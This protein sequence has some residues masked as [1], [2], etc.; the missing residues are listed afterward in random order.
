[1]KMDFFKAKAAHIRMGRRGE[2]AACRLLEWKGLEVLARDCKTPR[3][4]IDIVARD[5]ATLVFAEVKTKRASSRSR[6][7][8]NLSRRQ[9]ARIYRAAFSYMKDIGSP[10][11]PFRF[12]VIEVR[13][14]AW[15]PKGI[16]HIEASFGESSLERGGPRWR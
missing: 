5:G 16:R 10:A 14:G 1:M 6:P 13:M 8:E 12:D 3:G 9:R 11:V 2:D 15:G 7:A 4:E